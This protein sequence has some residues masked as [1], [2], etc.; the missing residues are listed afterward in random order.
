MSIGTLFCLLDGELQYG[1]AKEVRPHA[2]YV[3]VGK[4]NAMR[5]TGQV[6]AGVEVGG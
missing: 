3:E 1:Y 2:R 6:N 4:K 5:Q